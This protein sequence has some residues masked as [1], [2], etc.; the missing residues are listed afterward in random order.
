MPIRVVGD[1]QWGV[2]RTPTGH[3]VWIFNNKGVRKWKLEP[4][5]LDP[6][7][8]AQVTVLLGA[9]RVTELRDVRTGKRLTARN[10][11]LCLPVPPGGWM[12]VSAT[13]GER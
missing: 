2:N 10:G 8:T 11:K 3:L 7:Q 12:V 4:E 9:G 1:C 6:T 13:E 5:Q